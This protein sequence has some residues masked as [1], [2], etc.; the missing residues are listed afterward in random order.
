MGRIRVLPDQIAK[1]IA[2]G[3]RVE[4]AGGT[5]LWCDEAALATGTSISVRDL[6]FN[7]PARKKFLRSE[8]TELAHIAS[9]ATHY[10]LAHPDKTFQLTADAGELLHVTPVG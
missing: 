7:V 4:S 5:M 8:Q 2:A 1:K 10:S 3:G 6:F 9:L